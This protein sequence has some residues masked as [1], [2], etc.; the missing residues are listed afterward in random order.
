MTANT[1]AVKS[2]SAAK[3]YN[4]ASL[5]KFVKRIGSTEYLVTVR[6]CQSGKEDLEQKLL[7]L[8]ES[9]VRKLA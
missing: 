2:A 7:R 4:G 3:A 8:I 6:Y 5:G 1:I 9:E